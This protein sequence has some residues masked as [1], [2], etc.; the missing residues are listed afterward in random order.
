MVTYGFRG[1]SDLISDTDQPSVRFIEYKNQSF[2]PIHED[3]I[4]KNIDKQLDHIHSSWKHPKE[5][6][7]FKLIQIFKEKNKEAKARQHR[8]FAAKHEIYMAGLLEE[9]RK[10]HLRK[11]KE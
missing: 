4:N 2:K 8:E 1:R 6:F 7:Q 11:L 3:E 10:N 5:R 9:A